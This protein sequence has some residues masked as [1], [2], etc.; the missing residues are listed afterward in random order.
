MNNEHTPYP[1]TCAQTGHMYMD[2]CVCTYMNTYIQ[3][4]TIHNR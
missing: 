4:Q 3:T 1:Q 2:V